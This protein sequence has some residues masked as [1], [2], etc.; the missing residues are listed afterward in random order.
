MK[1]C[2]SS[3]QRL[4][5]LTEEWVGNGLEG[6]VNSARDLQLMSASKRILNAMNGEVDLVLIGV[7]DDHWQ[8]RASANWQNLVL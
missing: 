3:L 1:R 5:V 8:K 6:N 7:R 2:A 4:N